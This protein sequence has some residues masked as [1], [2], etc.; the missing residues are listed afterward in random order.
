[1]EYDYLTRVCGVSAEEVEIGGPAA[2]AAKQ[3][4]S[5][6]DAPSIVFFSEPY[7]VFSGRGEEFY[8]DLVLR[9]A[10]LAEDTGRELVIKLHP[11]ESMR[12]RWRL[13]KKVAP[14]RYRGIRLMSGP[15]SD[16]LLQKAWF[17]ITVLSTAAMDCALRGVPCFL[18][19]W[20][21]YFSCGYGE[22]F[23]KF[24]VCTKLASAAEIAVI[25]E[26]LE[27]AK[28]KASNGEDL[29]SPIAPERLRELLSGR[30]AARQA[31]AV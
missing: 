9:L 22:Q 19:E 24:G 25:P 20:L 1:M 29:S 23:A 27:V 6:E 10:K 8:R 7:E 14:E 3:R 30:V 21:E 2:V 11:M 5:S 17:G 16:E 26:M 12:E 4:N 31:A 15:L 18:C 13:V 28:W